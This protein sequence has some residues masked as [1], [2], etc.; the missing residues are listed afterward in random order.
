MNLIK[1]YAK[2]HNRNNMN[3]RIKCPWRKS[4]NLGNKILEKKI[5]DTILSK[6]LIIIDIIDKN[7]DLIVIEKPPRNYINQEE[8]EKYNLHVDPNLIQLQ[9][10]MYFGPYLGEKIR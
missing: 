5:P 7:I 3:N 1:Y 9:A 2:N 10:D 6:L 8:I 4:P